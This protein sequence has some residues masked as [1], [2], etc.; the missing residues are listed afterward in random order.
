MKNL[1][2][3]FLLISNLSFAQ[4]DTLKSYLLG[5]IIVNAQ[6]PDAYKNLS[7][8]SINSE[9]I[10]T[11]DPVS[12]T[13]I[14]YNYPGIYLKNSGRNEITVNIR[15]YDQRQI[16]VYFDGVPIYVPYDGM[17]DLNKIPVA[18]VSKITVTKNMPSMLYGAN[19]MGGTINIITDEVR[20]GIA[21][22]I[23]IQMGK[24]KYLSFENGG[25]LNKFFWEAS[26]TYS[27][28]DG[29]TLPK[30]MNKTINEDGGIRDNS[31]SDGYSGFLKVGY[32][33]SQHSNA[34][35]SFYHNDN[36]CGVPVN[37]Y[38]SYPRFW[39][40][41]EW[42]KSIVNFM[43]QAFVSNNFYIKGNFFFDKYKNVLDSY[44]D[45]SYTLQTKKYSFHSTYDDHSI[46]GNLSAEF[47]SKIISPTKF[48]LL[49]KKDVHKEQ[50]KIGAPF[51]LYENDTYTFG[52]E[53]EIPLTNTVLSIAG[54]NYDI[55]NPVFAN[56]AGV[57]GISSFLNGYLGISAELHTSLRTYVHISRKSRFPTLK[58]LYSEVLGRNIANPN[59]SSENS[60][61]AEIGVK[62]IF[63]SEISFNC[64]LF[65]N[66]IKDLIVLVDLPDNKRQFQN[67]GQA[68]LKGVEIEMAA[69]TSNF[70]A[71][72]SYTFL[73]A[74]NE[75]PSALSKNL[76][77][78]PKHMLHITLGSNYSFGFSWNAETSYF[79]R[80]FGANPDNLV[81]VEMP[82]YL[83][84][85]L[86]A[87]YNITNGFELFARI[88]NLTDKYY[89]SE[90]GYPQ[91]GRNVIIGI[92]LIL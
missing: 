7:Q 49:Y 18:S 55:I 65:R 60:I 86:R 53:Q 70:D 21:S 59:L 30:A 71:S 44:D 76:Q 91:S 10:K 58:E 11:K 51:S 90:F 57:R 81:W 13:D 34:A 66:K 73:S 67:I 52:I 89:E 37:I 29:F 75:T 5:E 92:N 19:T 48:A 23:D 8:F 9:E 64:N 2:V 22:K 33:F 15:G 14:L 82:D 87:A 43:Y 80:Q 3:L 54:L 28:S 61:N 68:E 83:L 25:A 26:G 46:G 40:F 6:N 39:K 85:N 27:K 45:A 74:V 42:K 88:N 4:T 77:Y 31:Q 32:H 12:V 78:K 69:K 24:T 62:Y 41:T 84:I 72:L 50:S 20:S 36:S 17:V 63:N 16:A 1:L 79:G 56:G 38:T 47:N 35:F